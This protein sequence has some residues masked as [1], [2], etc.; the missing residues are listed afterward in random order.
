MKL[1]NTFI[2]AIIAIIAYALIPTNHIVSADKKPSTV[3]SKVFLRFD[4]NR[5]GIISKDDFNCLK[6][7]LISSKYY[8]NILNKDLN[9]DGKENIVDLTVIKKHISSASKTIYLSSDGDDGNSGEI[10]SPLATLNYALEIAENDGIIYVM[11]K[12]DLPA[13][14]EWEEHSKTVTI[15]GDIL[16]CTATPRLKVR[17]G[18]T[19]QNIDIIF[20]ESGILYACGNPFRIEKSVNITG[21]I[22]F[23]GGDTEPVESTNATL[24]SGNYSYIYGGGNYADVSGDILLNVGGKVNNFDLSGYSEDLA[25]TIFGGCIEGNVGG[26]IR[27]N[28]DGEINQ[29]LNYKSHKPLA[30]VYGGCNSGNIRGNIELNIG[31]DTKFNYIVGGSIGNH[32][33]I[34]EKITLNFSGNAMSV[35]GGNCDNTLNA[36]TEVN[37]LGGWTEQVF[38]GCENAS[39]VGNATVNLLG[40]TVVRRVFGGCYNNIIKNYIPFTAKSN[41]HVSGSSTVT[42]SDEVNIECSKKGKFFEDFGISAASRHSKA[43]DDEESVITF[44]NKATKEK[45]SNKLGVSVNNKILSNFIKF[46][47]P[48]DSLLIAE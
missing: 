21:E 15:T 13:D 4:L 36:N 22:V 20:K 32:T 27:L 43:F 42:I 18:V 48:Y 30:C 23:F 8:D 46:S 12:F 26:N 47:S 33:D 6:S 9:N 34:G 14:F 1:Y 29:N 19:F 44:L 3:S 38:G 16:D 24:L 41:Y 40:G 7:E 25:H 2:F 11:N 37:I 17:D 28:I 10:T 39:M 31:T 35:V 5:D 45:Y